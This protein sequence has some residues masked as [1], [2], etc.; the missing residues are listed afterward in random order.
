[1]ST[2]PHYYLVVGKT[3]R[4]GLNLYLALFSADLSEGALFPVTQSFCRGFS[5]D[6]HFSATCFRSYQDIASLFLL[7]TPSDIANFSIILFVS[8]DLLN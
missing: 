7:S 8:I 3:G 2:S 1:M 6:E 5:N 4:R